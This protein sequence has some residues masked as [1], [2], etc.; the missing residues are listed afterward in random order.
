MRGAWRLITP[1]R[2]YHPPV[3]ADDPVARELRALAERDRAAGT[4]I[5]DWSQQERERWLKGFAGWRLVR[6]HY[7]PVRHPEK[8][9]APPAWTDELVLLLVVTLVAAYTD[10]LPD[11]AWTM[12]VFGPLWHAMTAL[13]EAARRR[14][15]RRLGLTPETLPRAATVS[16]AA[17]LVP[18]TLGPW[19]WRKL[20]GES[21][22]RDRQTWAF[23]LAARVIAVVNERRSWRQATRPR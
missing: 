14:S 2:R 11:A 9:D 15:A 12:V 6:A 22:R 8:L 16:G 3:A 20:R 23:Y 7:D 10:R 17:F 18:L 4:T 13:E 1:G 21:T 19:T 5:G